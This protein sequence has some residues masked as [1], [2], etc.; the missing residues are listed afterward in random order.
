MGS[1][2]A[3]S[4]LLD[5]SNLEKNANAASATAAGKQGLTNAKEDI[6]RMYD[7]GLARG[8]QQDSIQ[9]RQKLSQ[10]PHANNANNIA[11]NIAGGASRPNLL[12][13]RLNPNATQPPKAKARQD[14]SLDE[15]LNRK[16]THAEEA[17][18]EWFE[19]FQTKLSALEKREYMMRKDEEITSMQVSV[20]GGRNMR[21]G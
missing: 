17:E 9:K 1:G 10:H 20:G 14:L 12:K 2:G 11:N 4:V 3:H 15:L 21:Q 19:G 13:D 18:E 5:M 7:I 8:Q 16:S 6:K